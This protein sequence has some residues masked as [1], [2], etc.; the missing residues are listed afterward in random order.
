MRVL[1]QAAMRPHVLQLPAFSIAAKFRPFAEAVLAWAGVMATASSG[2]R[3]RAVVGWFAAHAVHPQSFLH[4]DGTS[5]NTSVLPGGETWATFN[6]TFG[7]PA[8]TNSDTDYW[9]ALFPNG[10]TML[11]K[12]IGTTAGNGAIADDGMLT[13]YAPGQWRVRNFPD[14]RSVQCTLQCKMAEVVLAAIGIPAVDISTNGHDPMMFYEIETG[15]W[16]YIDPTFGEMLKISDAHL[17]VLDL[18]EASINGENASIT[19]EKLPGA[20]YIPVGYF[21][22]PNVP[23]NGMSFMTVHTKPQWAGGLSARDPYRFG[24]LP[25]QSAANDRPGTIAQLMP[26]LGAAVAGLKQS[27]QTVEIRL[28]SNWVDHVGFER[29]ADDGATWAASGDIDYRELSDGDLRYRSVDADG[30]AG[31]PALVEI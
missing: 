21:D 9:Y 27:R 4:P 18:L 17:S 28:R 6:A 10:I 1:S 31:T 2:D 7:T 23:V 16:L 20:A 8:R 11:E 13:E 29:S 12:L 15:R 3:A 22:S 24:N 25:S 30:F 19:S 14:F 5:L 26:V